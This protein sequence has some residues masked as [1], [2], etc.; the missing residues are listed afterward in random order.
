MHYYDHDFIYNYG[1]GYRLD[2]PKC[3]PGNKP[4]G[5][6]CIPSKQNC[7]ITKLKGA[8]YKARQGASALA[9]LAATGVVTSVAGSYVVNEQFR[10]SVNSGVQNFVENTKAKFNKK[11]SNKPKYKI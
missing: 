10:N 11:S 8:G 3:S 5:R 4:C 9:Q 2:S 7:T 6:I 1:L